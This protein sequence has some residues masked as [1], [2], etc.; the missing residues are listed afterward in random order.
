MA[1]INISLKAEEHLKGLLKD[2]AVDTGIRMFAVNPGTSAA[3]CGVAYCPQN[4][5]TK[6]DTKFIF[7]SFDVYIDVD[8]IEYLDDAE[9]DYIKDD[10]GEHLTIKAPHVKLKPLADN[11]TLTERVEH[12][13]QNKINP[14][15]ASHGGLVTL[16]EI[17]QENEV[18]LQFGGGC[19]GCAMAGVT[20]KNG[21]EKELLN[22]FASEIIAVKDFTNHIKS[23]SSYYK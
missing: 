17:T 13:I 10:T 5:V 9:L 18:I 16:I 6:D 22:E 2:Q 23:D 14:Q 1:N 15:L 20:L 21:I 4:T 3:E 11:A 12:Y 8:S 7:N 19:V